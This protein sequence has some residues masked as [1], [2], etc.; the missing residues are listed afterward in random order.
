MNE[1][2]PKVML[3]MK[4]DHMMLMGLVMLVLGYALLFGYLYL[5]N[6]ISN[7]V[8]GRVENA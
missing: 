7:V 3:K 2:E 4:S 5:E 8:K 1:Q 6:E